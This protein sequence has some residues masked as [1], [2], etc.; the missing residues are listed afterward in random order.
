MHQSGFKNVVGIGGT[1]LTDLQATI[2]KQYTSNIFVLLDGDSAGKKAAIRSGY[3]L[4]KNSIDC[5]IICPP[6]NFD[7]DDWLLTETG[8]KN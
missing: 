8:K 6:N 7:P 1:S 2:I 4:L 5:K 3:T